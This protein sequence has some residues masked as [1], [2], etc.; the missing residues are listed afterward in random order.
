VTK[1]VE[2]EIPSI[3]LDQDQV[4]GFKHQRSPSPTSKKPKTSN[5]E[6]AVTGSSKINSFFTTVTFLGLA[7][8]A[9]FF[10]QE[11]LKIQNHL[12]QSEERIQLLENQLSATG[13]EMGESTIALKVKLEAI[14]E[15]SEKLWSEMDKLWASAWRRNQSEIK[16]L[17]SSSKK[18]LTTYNANQKDIKET[19]QSVQDK[20]T[21]T[22]LNVNALNDQL[23]AASGLQ[24]KIDNLMNELASLDNK[25]SNRDEQQMEI[26][27]MVNQ[28]DM[29]VKALIERLERL[30]QKAPATP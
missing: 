28:L 6:T 18:H 17:R 23:S 26:A 8:A 10:Y 9:F 1:R 30:E 13:E 25:A 22:D 29:S 3:K 20:Q 5:G 15:K 11:N 21:S 19:L 24:N 16:E 7:G 14:T 4:E 2:P 12:A 27:T